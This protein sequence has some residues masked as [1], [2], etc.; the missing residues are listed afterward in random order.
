MSLIEED[1][2]PIINNSQKTVQNR[3]YLTRWYI[4]A[5]FSI[6]SALQVHKF[7]FELVYLKC[8]SIIKCYFANSL[9]ES[10]S[11]NLDRDWEIVRY[12]SKLLSLG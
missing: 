1:T 12:M 7:Y 3:V 4:L 2:V 5:V 11:N 8:F 10:G 9:M 6:L